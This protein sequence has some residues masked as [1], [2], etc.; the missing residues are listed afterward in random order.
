MRLLIVVDV[1]DPGLT[2][3]GDAGARLYGEETA[4]LRRTG[5]RCPERQCGGY[6]STVRCHGVLPCEA[7]ARFRVR[8]LFRGKDVGRRLRSVEFPQGRARCS[9]IAVAEGR[10]GERQ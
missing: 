6:D 1:A 4:R 8:V 7:I 9:R 2:P 5:E 3:G 10:G